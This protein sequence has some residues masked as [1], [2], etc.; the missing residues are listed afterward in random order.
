[1]ESRTVHERPTTRHEAVS[2]RAARRRVPRSRGAVSGF[3]LVL[4]GIWAGLIPFVGPYFNYEFGS[5]NTWVMTWD[6]AWLEVLPAAA[7][8]FGGLILLGSRS[9]IGGILGGWL[10]LAG[11]V[12]FVIGPS[13]SMLWDSSLGPAAPGD[14]PIGSNGVQFLEYIGFFYGVGALGTALAAFALGRFSV[15]GVRDVEYAGAT[16]AAP[17]VARRDPDDGS[18]TAP[19]GP[20]TG[21][22]TRPARE[23]PAREAPAGEAPADESAATTSP[24]RGGRL[25]RLFRRR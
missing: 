5:D 6:R 18:A 22:A 23:A 14:L 15:V 8:F 9:R 4:L 10:A 16:A 19:A 7:L 25:R 2:P 3:L 11:G 20:G 21:P 1:M 13:F 17:T 24:T 12:W